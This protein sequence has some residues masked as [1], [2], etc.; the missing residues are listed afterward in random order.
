[1][2]SDEVLR[3]FNANGALSWLQSRLAGSQGPVLAPRSA[4]LEHAAAL[5]DSGCSAVVSTP[6]AEGKDGTRGRKDSKRA[7]VGR[8]VGRQEHAENAPAADAAAGAAQSVPWSLE[9]SSGATSWQQPIRF[10]VFNEDPHARGR[11]RHHGRQPPVAR[12]V[13][14]WQGQQQGQQLLQ[15]LQPPPQKVRD[16]SEQTLPCV[17]DPSSEQHKLQPQ[18]PCFQNQMTQSVQQPNFVPIAPFAP[19][20]GQG[21]YY[22]QPCQWGNAEDYNDASATQSSLTDGTTAPKGN[23]CSTGPMTNQAGQQVFMVMVPANQL[24]MPMGYGNPYAA[25]TWAPGSGDGS[26]WAMGPG[27]FMN[28]GGTASNSMYG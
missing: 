18:N 25:G 2:R 5:L 19:P 20:H 15:Q 13:S 14:S 21:S 26:N 7:V 27:Q 17:Q 12:P 28:G 4:L 11:E 23:A 1:M 24:G 10:G 6:Q 16:C 8:T 22:A 3:W 9:E